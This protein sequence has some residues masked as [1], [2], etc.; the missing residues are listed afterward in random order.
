[1]DIS[2][3]AFN[4]LLIF[5][6]GI[7]CA[8]MVDMFTNH[9]ERT[10][11]QFIINAFLLG[12]GSYLLFAGI[13]YI[14]TPDKLSEINFIHAL[15]DGRAK[16]SLK[17]ILLVCGVSAALAVIIIVINTHKLHFRIFQFLKIT[18]KFGEQDVWGFMMNSTST[19]WITVR[20]SENNIMYDG[21]VKAF[22]DN[23][24]EAELL[25]ENVSVYRNDS[26]EHL[27]NTNAQYLSLSKDKISIEIR[28]NS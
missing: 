5:F 9:R 24:K 1:M 14:F 4:L 7:I 20:D 6:P 17:E 13:V 26:G 8:Y 28:S 16:I 19:E 18:K 27:Y 11:F 23:S 10:Q 2:E 25:L 22:S 3:F 21:S 15:L 12:F